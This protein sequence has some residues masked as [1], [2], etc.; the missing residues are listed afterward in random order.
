MH[1]LFLDVLGNKKFVDGYQI[2]D[3]IARKWLLK[4]GDLS[5]FTGLRVET[6]SP[7]I[8]KKR[9]KETEN[10]KKAKN[11]KKL[12]PKE[13]KILESDFAQKKG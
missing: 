13:Q 12:S 5:P 3:S 7:E 2:D 8:E 10:L 11:K 1:T 4:P 6:L 9:K